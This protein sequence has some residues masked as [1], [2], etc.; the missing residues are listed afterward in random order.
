M[1]RIGVREL[2]QNA[3]EYLRRVETGEVIEVTSRGRLVARLVPAR[4]RGLEQLEREG[5]IS[6]SHG[7]FLDMPPPLPL[8]RG[9]RPPSQI[10]A[11]MREHER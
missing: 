11:E 7:S 5:R 4:G 3:S 1:D 2:R 9:E 6:P 10:L 8:R